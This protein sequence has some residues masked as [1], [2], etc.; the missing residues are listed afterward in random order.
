PGT[1]T[2]LGV[3]PAPSEYIDRVTGSLSL[4]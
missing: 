2:A 4:L 3:G 1:V